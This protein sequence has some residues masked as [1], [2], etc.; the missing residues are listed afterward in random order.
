MRQSS[1]VT[2]RVVVLADAEGAEGVQRGQ[3]SVQVWYAV[4]VPCVRRDRT[5][6]VW[7]IRRTRSPQVSPLATFTLTTRGSPNSFTT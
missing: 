1:D 7:A 4:G 6:S 5:G 3:V 2:H